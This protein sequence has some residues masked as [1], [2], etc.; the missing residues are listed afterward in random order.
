MPVTVPTISFTIR[1]LAAQPSSDRRILVFLPARSR[2]S[3][4][5]PHI[6]QAERRTLPPGFFRVNENT[7]SPVTGSMFEVDVAHVLPVIERGID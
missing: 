3:R 4:S 1:S 2:S 6:F 7:A 5:A